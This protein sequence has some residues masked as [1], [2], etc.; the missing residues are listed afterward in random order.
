[1]LLATPELVLIKHSGLQKLYDIPPKWHFWQYKTEY[2]SILYMKLQNSLGSWY[3]F[4]ISPQRNAYLL[5]KAEEQVS[6]KRDGSKTYWW[7]G[8]RD[9]QAASVFHCCHSA[10]WWCSVAVGC[11]SVLQHNN[12]HY[13]NDEQQLCLFITTNMAKCP[14]NTTDSYCHDRSWTRVFQVKHSNNDNQLVNKSTST[15]KGTYDLTYWQELCYYKDTVWCSM[16]FLHPVTLWLFL[17]Q[18]TKGQGCYST[19]TPVVI[20]RLKADWMWNWK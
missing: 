12:H 20:Y 4:R 9:K 14:P 19:S 11:L 5:Q 10:N 17:L 16:Y 13:S 3:L 2:S 15:A 6:V 7:L 8:Q 1:M 18:L